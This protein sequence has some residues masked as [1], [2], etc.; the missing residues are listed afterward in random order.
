MAWKALRE[1][2]PSD[3]DRMDPRGLFVG[4]LLALPF[5]MGVLALLRAA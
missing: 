2:I 4:L 3:R 5:W 1:A